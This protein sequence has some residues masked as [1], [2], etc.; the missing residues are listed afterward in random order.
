MDEDD[1]QPSHSTLEKTV[2]DAEHAF[3]EVIDDTKSVPNDIMAD[4]RLFC[5][6]T[7][8]LWFADFR[9]LIYHKFLCRINGGYL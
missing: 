7:F 9:Y 8:T 5:C 6:Y 4:I 3:E 2:H 1:D